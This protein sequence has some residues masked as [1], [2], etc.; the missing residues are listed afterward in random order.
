MS[1]QWK[2][3]PVDAT[4]AMIDAA[5]KVEEDGYDAMHKAMLAAAPVPP[6]G[7]VEVLTNKQIREKRYAEDQAFH[8]WAFNKKGAAIG[9]MKGQ[10]AGLEAWHARGEIADAEVTR[11]TAERD[12]LRAELCARA[13]QIGSLAGERDA[14]HSELTKARELL[15]GAFELACRGSAIPRYFID[16]MDKFFREERQPATPIAHNVDESCGQDAE[17]AK[18]ARC[19]ASTVENCDEKGCGFLGAGNGA[20]AAKGCNAC[21]APSEFQKDTQGLIFCT[22]CGGSRAAAK[23][24]A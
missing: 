4:R 20:P 5:A 24:G 8:S 7:D 21:G 15:K 13:G 10:V 16:D 23:G 18:C 11:L 14:A 22:N 17:A 2:M 12:G 6:A 19:E 9:R 3:V 1:N